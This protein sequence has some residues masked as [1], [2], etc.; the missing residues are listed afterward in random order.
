MLF[1]LFSPVFAPVLFTLNTL[2]LFCQH[3]L[4]LVKGMEFSP[5]VNNSC[6]VFSLLNIK[7]GIYALYI[8]EPASD[9]LILLAVESV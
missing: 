3:P 8:T 2:L 9:S 1:P 7:T 5:G 4:V 6:M